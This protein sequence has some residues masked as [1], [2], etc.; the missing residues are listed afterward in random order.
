LGFDA[1]HNTQRI[2]R[3]LLA[4]GLDAMDVAITTS[5]GN[6]KLTQFHVVTDEIV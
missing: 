4:T 1:R 2:G 5:F 6:A 3:V